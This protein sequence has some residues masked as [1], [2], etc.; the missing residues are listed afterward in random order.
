MGHLGISI[1]FSREKNLAI[2]LRAYKKDPDRTLSQVQY[3]AR[4]SW[5]R[6]RKGLNFPDCKCLRCHALHVINEFKN[7]PLN[8]DSL[9]QVLDNDGNTQLL[10]T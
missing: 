10:C 2:I 1:N 3:L 8:M 4:F 7:M 6:H 5:N 9:I